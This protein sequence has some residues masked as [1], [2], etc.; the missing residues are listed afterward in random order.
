MLRSVSCTLSSMRIAPS[1]PISVRLNKFSN[2]LVV[3]WVTIK[4]PTPSTVQDRLISMARFFAVKK[5]RAMRRLG[6]IREA[7]LAASLQLG[8]NILALAKIAGIFDND[9]LVERETP[10]HLDGGK[11]DEAECH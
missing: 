1:L 5:R 2:P 7:M 9:L 11:A 3:A 4:S 6:D 8:A 10:R